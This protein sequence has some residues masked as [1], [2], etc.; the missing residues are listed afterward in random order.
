ME[1][2]VLLRETT[3]ILVLLVL[4]W[5]Q[6]EA[7][8][9]Q[10]GWFWNGIQWMVWD[11]SWRTCSNATSC[12]SCEDFMY[13][14]ST[15]NKWK[16]WQDGQYYDSTYQIWRNWDGKWT[17]YWKGQK[18]WF[19][20]DSGKFLDLETL[21]CVTNWDALKYQVSSSQ[22]STGELWRLSQFYVDPLSS[23]LIELGTISYPY[24][25]MKAVSSDILNNFS[26]QNMNIIKNMVLKFSQF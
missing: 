9:W 15:T 21:S 20:W 24:K 1:C 8:S 10:S 11:S 26:H 5:L 25:S 6:V 13:Y 2:H 3:L 4:F 12:D 17:G 19:V 23:E 7:T 14:D 16:F 22:Y 18:Q